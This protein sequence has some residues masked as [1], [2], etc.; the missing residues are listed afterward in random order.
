M[1]YICYFAIRYFTT[2]KI[3]SIKTKIL[4][5]YTSNKIRYNSIY[6][7]IVWYINGIKRLNRIRNKSITI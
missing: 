6:K 1:F 2:Q 4:Y 5:S 3:D 7:F